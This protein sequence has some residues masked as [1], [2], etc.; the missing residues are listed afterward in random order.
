[1][2]AVVEAVRRGLINGNG[3]AFGGGVDALSCV[4]LQGLETQIVAHVLFFLV[5]YDD[6]F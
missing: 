1:V 4:Q 3:P 2:F 6:D 5:F